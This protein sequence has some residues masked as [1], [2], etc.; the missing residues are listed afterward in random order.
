MKAILV[1]VDYSDNARNAFSY[2]LEIAKVTGAEVI[3]LHAFF[4]IMSPPASYDAA[5]VVL[6]METG[7]LKELQH[8]A[9]ISMKALS[10]TAEDCPGRAAKPYGSI[11]VSCVTKMGG[12]FDQ[13]MEAIEAYHVDLVVMGMQGGNAIS[14]AILGSTTISVM[15]ESPVPVLAVPKGIQYKGFRSVAF[16][17]NLSKLPE[18]ADLHMLRDFIKVL[19]AK[20]Q[21]LH[22]YQTDSQF[23]MF[24][25]RDAL[26]TLQRNFQDVDYDFSFDF[27]KDVAAGIQDFIQEEQVDLLVLIPQ[28]HNVIER[29]LDQSITGKITAHPLVPLL[30][31]PSYLLED[32]ESIDEAVT[33]AE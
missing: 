33:A 22:L 25:A 5:D 9:D 17:T 27:R 28:K 19:K 14:Q 3:L 26:A 29:L 1:P 13:I 11:K 31:L 23:R 6:A 2:G 12:S 16:A 21:V 30:A 8:F 18:N 24:D 10:A 20:L 15:Q 7:K 32:N 4:P